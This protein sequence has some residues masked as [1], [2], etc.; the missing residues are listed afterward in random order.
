[1]IRWKGENLVQRDGLFLC[2]FVF[3][4][5]TLNRHRYD[6][7]MRHHWGI[8]GELR[9]D[10][11]AWMECTLKFRVW[12]ARNFQLGCCLHLSTFF[13]SKE[14]VLLKANKLNG[15]LGWVGKQSK[16]R[17]IFRD[18]LVREALSCW[19]RS[20]VVDL[21]LFPTEVPWK[22]LSSVTWWQG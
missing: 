19:G 9:A 21:L 11:V 5:L 8:S 10:E 18:P 7:V 1:M 3:M 15:K 13:R 6:A 2:K 22:N 14:A 20:L 17:L 16:K 4:K 12:M